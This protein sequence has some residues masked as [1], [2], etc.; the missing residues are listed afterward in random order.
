MIWQQR[1]HEEN[2]VSI[3]AY[4]EIVHI[5]VALGGPALHA[6]NANPRLLFLVPPGWT[7]LGGMRVI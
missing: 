5:D 4:E 7:R 1:K 2:L 6:L 3:A